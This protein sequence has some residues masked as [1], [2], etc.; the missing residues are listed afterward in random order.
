MA[1]SR[2]LTAALS[3]LLSHV[4]SPVVAFDERRGLAYVNAA[5]EAWLGVAGEELAGRRATY[6]TPS[7]DASHAEQ[8]VAAICPPAEVFA[9]SARSVVVACPQADGALSRRRVSFVPL[10]EAGQPSEAVLGVVEPV[11]S[12][13]PTDDGPPDD[14]AQLHLRLQNL[15]R[16]TSARYGLDQLVGESPA[17]RRVRRQ[18]QLAAASPVRTVIVGP[19]GSGREHIARSIHFAGRPEYAAP[20]LPLACGL[21]DAEL[22]QT[23]VTAFVRRAA[24]SDTGRPA[25]LLLLDVDQLDGA[26]QAEL[27]GFLNLPGFDVHILSTARTAPSELAATG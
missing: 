11:E 27:A 18:A 12:N 19:E 6:S 4:Q 13:G 7:G 5:F 20:L 21:M 1:R 3:Q 23:S 15:R 2:S 17:I 10:G 8:I 24:R 16:E 26:A 9:G 25:A 14:A 22:L